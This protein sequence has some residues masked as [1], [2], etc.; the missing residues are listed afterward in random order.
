MYT[1]HLKIKQLRLEHTYRSMHFSAILKP[2][3]QMLKQIG[4][5]REV[6]ISFTIWSLFNGPCDESSFTTDPIV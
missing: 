4:A 1:Y 5:A 2:D 6:P 3:I